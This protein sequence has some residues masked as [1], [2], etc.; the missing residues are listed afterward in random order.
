MNDKKITYEQSTMKSC[1]EGD[2]TQGHTTK[3]DTRRYEEIRGDMM[4]YEEVRYEQ[5]SIPGH[6]LHK[7]GLQKQKG[8]VSLVGSQEE[9]ALLVPV[10]NR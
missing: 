5:M 1:H 4:R 8:V 7:K 2:T 10:I 9:R 3:K 6:A